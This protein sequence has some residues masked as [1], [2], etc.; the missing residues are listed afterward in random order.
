MLCAICFDEIDG[1]DG[2][3]LP[4]CQHRFHVACMLSAAQYDVRCPVCRQVP[5]DV[6][7]R[8]KNDTV[9]R[10]LEERTNA[11]RNEWIRYRTRRRR[12]LNNNP[13][14]LNAFD[15]L[16]V[17]RAQIER[18]NE[19]AEREYKRQCREVWSTNSV[20]REHCVRSSRLR[21]RERRLEQFLHNEL[22]CR[23]GSEP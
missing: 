18:E 22:R 20:I 7:S 15:R 17:L 9:Y 2:M 4:G 21:R 1:D 12:C 8:P 3:I 14:L 19:S 13:V 6:Q 23:I 11:A 10:L 5:V 16:K